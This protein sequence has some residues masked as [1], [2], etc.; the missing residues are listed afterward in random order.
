MRALDDWY[1]LEERVQGRF[2]AATGR[3]VTREDAEGAYEVAVRSPIFCEAEGGVCAVCCGLD[4]VTEAPF[5]IGEPVGLHAAHALVSKLDQIVTRRFH[6]GGTAARIGL[7]ICE[8]HAE[9]IVVM[10]AAVTEEEAIAVLPDDKR[11][12]VASWLDFEV[13]NDE[14]VT[15]AC[16]G[17][18]HGARVLVKSGQRVE[19]GAPLAEWAADRPSILARRSGTVRWVGIVEGIT[20]QE[21]LDEVTGLSRRQV[22]EPGWSAPPRIEIRAADGTLLET[23]PLEVDDVLHAGD[24]EGIVR[25]QPVVMRW[26]PLSRVFPDDLLGRPDLLWILDGRMDEAALLSEIGGVV[27]VTKEVDRS[28]TIV[29]RPAVKDPHLQASGARRY[30]VPPGH[31]V[32]VLDG[33]R[34]APGDPIRYGRHAPGDIARIFG[35]AEGALRIV[36]TI[37]LIYRL[38]GIPLHPRHAELVAKALLR[39]VRVRDPGDGPWASGELVDRACFARVAEALA[40]RGLAAPSAEVAVTGIGVRVGQAPASFMAV[41]TREK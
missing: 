16:G 25:G 17:A 8:A 12:V 20:V 18:P 40:R 14:G 5:A 38:F 10:R 28:S 35:P 24:G 2:A 41:L 1:P 7:P 13:V 9:G 29:V 15:V 21:R 31:Y 37:Q 33:E 36:D 23:I 19:R 39:A 26:R 32:C 34:V 4:P 3:L 22:V 11:V 6:I 30:T 27:E